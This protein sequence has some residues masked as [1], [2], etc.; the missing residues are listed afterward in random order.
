MIWPLLLALLAGSSLGA[1]EAPGGG[2][3]SLFRN[4]AISRTEVVFEYGGDLWIA[5]RSGGTA[6]RLTTGSGT[7]ANPIFSPD[8]TQIAFTGQY[9]GNV[10]VFLV[11]AAGGVPKRL[12]WHPGNDTAVAWTPDS[13][14]VV[15]A[16]NRSANTPRYQELFSISVDGGAETRMPVPVG[17]EAAFAPDGKRMAYVPMG[18]AFTAWKRYRGGMTTPIWIADLTTSKVE[19]LPRDNANDYCPMWAGGK[20]WFLSDRSGVVTLYSYDPQTKKVARAVENKGLDFKS[21]S[22]GPD[23]IVIEQLGALQLFDWKSGKL[24]PLQVTVSADLAE[25]RERFVKIGTRLTNAAVSPSGVRAVFEGRGEI[26][27]VPAE[28]GDP[29]NLTNSA[30]VMERSPAWSPDGKRIAYFS[31]ASGEYDLHV[32]AQDGKGDVKQ[33]RIEEKRTF[34]TNPV[35]SPDSKKIAFLDVHLSLWTLDVDSGK[36]VK[37]DTDRYLSRPVS[38]SWSPDSKWLA[39]TKTLKNYMGAVYVHNLAEG[40]STQVTDGMSDARNPVWDRSGK[41]LYFMASTNSGPALQP[42]IQSAIRTVTSSIYLIVLAKT[43][44]SPLAP[45][46]DEEKPAEEK[47]AEAPKADGDKPAASAAAKPAAVKIDFENL[48][49]RVLSMPMPPRRYVGL[50]SGK[51]GTL[52]ALEAPVAAPGAPQGLSVHRFDLK[53][54]RGDVPVSNV[55]FFRLAHNGEK[56]LYRQQNNWIIAAIRPLPPRTAPAAGGP[57]PGGPPPTPL[58]TA[59]LEVKVNPREEWAQMYRDAWRIQREL[60]YDPGLHGVNV[61]DFEARY[62]KY[63]RNLSSRRDLTY[64]MQDMMGEISVGHLGVFGGEQPEVKT[65]QTGLLGADYA[66]VNGRYQFKRIFSG[67]N[68]NPGLLAPLTQPG[69]N[70]NPGDFLLRVDGREVMATESVHSFFEAKAGKQVRLRVGPNAD[71]SEARDVMVVPVASEAGLRNLAWIEENRRK[72]DKATNGRVAYVYMPDTSFGGLTNFTRYFYAQVGKEAAIIDERYN[73]GGAL[74]TDIV[75]LLTQ[76]PLSRVATR[77]GED[78]LQPQGAIYG[79]KVMIINEWAGSGGDA[80]PWYFRRAGAGPLVGKRTWGGLVGR[81]GAPSLMDGGI[82]SAPSSAVWDPA[83]SKW[84]AENVGVE[85]DIEVE[86]E[87]EL[88]EQGKDPQLEKAIE[89]V[90]AE[91][92]KKPLVEPKRPGY[93][94]YQ[95]PGG[96][97]T[98]G[99]ANATRK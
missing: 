83:T 49:Q 21:A 5:A 74:A 95:V 58:K 9:D 24:T 38:P 75:G 97:P 35:W 27:T 32:V 65:V 98:A 59:D 33:F 31:D 55:S 54:R 68:W 22:A 41:Y 88:V 39:Y 86:N 16:S 73:G 92:A 63:I 15:F 61:A 50:Q 60:F 3:P 51:A 81:A 67:E 14:R 10:D 43:E 79:P 1:Q 42:D 30:A 4:P 96:P 99:T 70:V 28:K 53:E 57:P 26:V 64:V 37:I 77:D 90:M 80:M 19:K 45:E 23:A 62:R 87:P 89:L 13:R 84:I 17:Y 85:P 76:K 34:Y 36:A 91:L 11:P 40:K 71:G 29:R 2:E 7:E 8:G 6:R 44:P 52:F 25:V 48:L 20:V 56:A 69:V 12:T 66:V 82:V 47:K 18:R 46:S 78:E 72:V 94:N 93:P